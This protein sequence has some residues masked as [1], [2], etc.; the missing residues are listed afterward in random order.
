MCEHLSF[1]SES[2]NKTQSYTLREVAPKRVDSANPLA[3]TESNTKDQSEHSSNSPEGRNI[4]T[5]NASSEGGDV[6]TGVPK[7]TTL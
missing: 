3:L 1:Y 2:P 4:S 6:S 5:D 7:E